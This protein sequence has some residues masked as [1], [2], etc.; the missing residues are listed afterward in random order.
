MISFFLCFPFVLFYF[1]HRQRFLSS[2][3][4][5]LLCCSFLWGGVLFQAVIVMVT[6]A[7]HFVQFTTYTPASDQKRYVKSSSNYRK[8][9]RDL[10]LWFVELELNFWLSARIAVT[11]LWKNYWYFMLF[12]V[13]K[14]CLRMSAVCFQ[15]FSD[16][17]V[18]RVCLNV[19]VLIL[20]V[21]VG[22]PLV[23]FGF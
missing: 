21:A 14:C 19:K 1:Q 5:P 11:L 4:F 17:N 16:G 9:L 15:E 13:K 10:F 20:F 12:F 22:F 8:V 7:F 23:C 18:V 2:F 6:D 3:F